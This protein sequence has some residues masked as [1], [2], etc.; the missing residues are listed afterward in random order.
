MLTQSDIRRIEE[1]LDKKLE[2]K[3]E[4]KLESKLE[5]KLEEKLNEKLK[6]FPSKEQFYEKMDQLMGEI[7]A[8]REEQELHAGQHT[9]IN[10]RLEEHEAQ[11]KKL[12]K[13]VGITV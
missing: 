11:L 12:A 3:L 1:L 10:D 6:Y 7:K 13:R 9:E 2:E 4:S 8:M 5:E